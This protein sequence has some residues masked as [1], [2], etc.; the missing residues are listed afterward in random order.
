MNFVFKPILA[1]FMMAVCS[2]VIYLK[3][4]VILP[5]KMCTIIALITAVIIYILS[6]LVL[7]ILSRDEIFMLP[8]GKKI[9]A[10]FEK[11]GIYKK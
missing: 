9:Y 4:A 5:I 1:T 6:V 10:I 11:I 7:K 8:Y 2:Y 3:L